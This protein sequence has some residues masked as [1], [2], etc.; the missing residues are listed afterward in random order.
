MADEEDDT[1]RKPRGSKTLLL[2]PPG[3]GKT[4][5]LVT[6]I[7]AGVEV[8]ALGTDPGFEES[9]LDAM[10][11]RG[12]LDKMHMLH[13]RYISAGVPSWDALK[14]AA[15]KVAQMSYKDLGEIKQGIDKHLYRQYLDVIDTLAN[16]T[17]DLCGK[18]F[19]PVDEFDEFKCVAVDS[20][21]GVNV[22]ALDMM[23]GGKPLAHMGEYGVAMNM[24]EKLLL[25]LCANLKCFVVVTAHLDKEPNLL[26]GIPQQMVG[27]L[28]SK[29]APKIPRTF[30][31]VV[32][33]VKEGDKFTWS[34][35]ALNVDLKNRALPISDNLKPDF[36]QMVDAWNE[37]VETW[38]LQNQ[39]K[40]VLDPTE[41]EP[42]QTEERT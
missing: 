33:A 24:E 18:S 42:N 22:M 6:F 36:A 28:G 39:N 27:A 1:R 41:T 23:I 37:R 34:T 4:T 29:L 14:N 3:T 35:A 25:A 16:F 26:T 32:L 12:L 31:D 19:G 2:G 17:C 38:E 11:A 10:K 5:A 15:N 21:T 30:S 9:I 40:T 20:L 7:E 13:Y 8:F